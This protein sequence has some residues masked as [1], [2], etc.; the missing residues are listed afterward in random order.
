MAA[1]IIPGTSEE[2]V[3]TKLA[4]AGNGSGSV[5]INEAELESQEVFKRTED[6]VDFRNVIPSAMYSLG[7]LGGALSVVGWS[8]MNTYTAVIQGDFKTRHP[9]CHT[10]ADMGY[11]VGGVWLKE[12]IGALYLIAFV[13]CAGTGIIGLSVAFNTLSD[14]AACTVWWGFLSTVIITI[15]ASIRTL[16]NIGWLTWVGFLSIFLAVFI[17]VI[18]VTTVDR[19]AAAP[20]TGPFDLGYHVIAYPTFAEGMTATTTIFVSSAGTSAFLPVISEMR[21]PRD[22]K[23]A[24]YI[25][26]GL[27]LCMYLSFSLVVYRWT[28]QWVANPSLGSAGGTI[29]KVSYGIGLVGL[30]V[31][32]CVYQHV[33]AK[34]LFVR[35]LR[36]TRHLQSNTA[37]H[38]GT[39]LGC[40]IGLGAVAFILAESIAIFNYLLSLVGSICFAPMAISV[41]GILWLF[42]FSHYRT[43]SLWQKSQY[44]FHWFL[45]VLG[46]F[47]TVGGTYSTIL[48]IKDAYATGLIGS[49]FSCA[50]NSNSGH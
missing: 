14:H 39:W 40:S 30:S 42:D 38:W 48:A 36:N 5:S 32:G 33:A 46:L 2:K 6:G 31:S 21:N 20:Q 49:A 18:G 1:V 7:A 24:L 35:I 22:F 16:R 28:G 50:D 8:I 45:V 34:Y 12:L 44:F 13:L 17:V 29:K 41:P 15:A 25:C 10:L 23:K 27:V 26:M 9:E 4:P 43:G 19:P 3:D 37:I 11:K 47:I